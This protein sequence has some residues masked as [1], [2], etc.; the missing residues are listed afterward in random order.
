LRAF[1]LLLLLPDLLLPCSAALLFCS[2]L[3]WVASQQ[4]AGC[5][6]GSSEWA[7]LQWKQQEL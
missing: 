1:L 4:T 5:Q 6:D 2:T 7:V 3:L